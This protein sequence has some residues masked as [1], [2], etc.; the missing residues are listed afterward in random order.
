MW[1]QLLF[2][3]AN[4][5]SKMQRNVISRLDFLLYFSFAELYHTQSTFQKI[6]YVDMLSVCQAATEPHYSYNVSMWFYQI[7]LCCIHFALRD[8][9]H[10]LMSKNSQLA[11]VEGMAKNGWSP[12]LLCDRGLLW[13][14]FRFFFVSSICTKQVLSQ[15]ADTLRVLYKSLLL[16]CNRQ[17]S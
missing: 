12:Q 14:N 1:L 8:S 5:V 16:L 7:Y 3:P 9:L 13:S 6:S 11:V 15:K 2:S 17:K 10:T 4:S